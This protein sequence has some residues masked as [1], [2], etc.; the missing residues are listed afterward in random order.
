MMGMSHEGSLNGLDE[1]SSDILAWR[2]MGSIGDDMNQD[3]D[4]GFLRI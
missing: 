4:C 2:N 3:V 1:F